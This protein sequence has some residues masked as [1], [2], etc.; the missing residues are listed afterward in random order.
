MKE[1]NDIDI[2]RRTNLKKRSSTITANSTGFPLHVEREIIIISRTTPRGK[3][4]DAYKQSP[5]TENYRHTKTS[6]IH[7]T[8][9]KIC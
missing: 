7:F 8:K 5:Q 6:K 1:I 9:A 3:K 4:K 2:R